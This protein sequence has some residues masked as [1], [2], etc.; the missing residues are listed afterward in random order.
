MQY[1]PTHS[2]KIKHIWLGKWHASFCYDIIQKSGSI[3]TILGIHLTISD[4]HF[5]IWP[6]IIV[7]LYIIIHAHRLRRY[8]LFTGLA[9]QVIPTVDHQVVHILLWWRCH[10]LGA[11]RS[12]MHMQASIMQSTI[13]GCQLAGNNSYYIWHPTP[14]TRRTS[15]HFWN[16]LYVLHELVILYIPNN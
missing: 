11:D 10:K 2:L 7:I 9:F 15:M 12:R 1:T 3:S 14:I 6:N 5:F 16:G 8:A 13:T 4:M